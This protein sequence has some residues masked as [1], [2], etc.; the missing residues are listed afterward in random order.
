[1][2]ER[3]DKSR[4][5]VTHEP[6][7]FAIG[8]QVLLATKDLELPT[9]FSRKLSPLYV[10]PFRVTQVVVPGRTVRLELPPSWKKIHPTFHVSRLRPWRTSAVFP[11]ATAPKPAALMVEESGAGWYSIDRLLAHQ[12]PKG[13]R[14]QYRYLVRWQGYD[15]FESEW[16]LATEVTPTAIAAYWTSRGEAV[17]HAI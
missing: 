14:R 12:P 15:D 6:G 11:R 17:P 4:R 9:H 7:N 3:E 8:D 13:R 1:M 16:K 5:K 2:R 10:G